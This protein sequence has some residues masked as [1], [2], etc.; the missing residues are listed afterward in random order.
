MGINLIKRIYTSTNKSE[1]MAKLKAYTYTCSYLSHEATKARV[2]AYIDNDCD[3]GITSMQLKASLGAIKTSLSYV[4]DALKHKVGAEIVD[5]IEAGDTLADVI[6][7]CAI[8]TK[9]PVLAEAWSAVPYYKNTYNF[10][11]GD[12]KKELAFMALYSVELMNIRFSGCDRQRLAYIKHLLCEPRA[13]ER[14]MSMKLNKWLHSIERGSLDE[15]NNII[16]KINKL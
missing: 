8:G 4:N 2:Q 11:I 14:I 9:K 7:E 6:I 1:T 16:D 15:V 3:M 13:D 12:C 5:M 10:N